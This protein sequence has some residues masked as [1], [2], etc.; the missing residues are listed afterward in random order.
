MSAG[1]HSF[2]SRLSA[3]ADGTGFFRSLVRWATQHELAPVTGVL[4]AC[5]N[6]IRDGTAIGEQGIEDSIAAINDDSRAQIRIGTLIL[7]D[8]RTFQKEREAPFRRGGTIG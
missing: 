5:R 7:T 2:G 8:S 4:G 3:A 6:Q 1:R